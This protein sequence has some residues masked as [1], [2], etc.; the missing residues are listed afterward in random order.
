MTQVKIQF[1]CSS[2]GMENQ[3][4]REEKL[5][6]TIR[7]REYTC[8]WTVNAMEHKDAIAKENAYIEGSSKKCTAVVKSIQKQRFFFEFTLTGTVHGVNFSYHAL[9]GII[10]DEP[11]RYEIACHSPVRYFVNTPPQT[12]ICCHHHSVRYAGACIVL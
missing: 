3:M 5:V 2:L 1:N 9:F 7:L 10:G 4:D 8:L 12:F 11:R 6:E